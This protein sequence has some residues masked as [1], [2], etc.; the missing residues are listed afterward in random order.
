M[1]LITRKTFLL[2]NNKNDVIQRVHGALHNLLDRLFIRFGSE[3]HRQSVGIQLNKL[4]SSDTD[5]PFLE[6]APLL[7]LYL[8][9]TNDI[10]S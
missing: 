10:V 9:I 2:L 6:I 3:L 5:A 1:W 7:T 8:S 4:N